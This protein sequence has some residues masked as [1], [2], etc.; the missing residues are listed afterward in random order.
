M[1]YSL[2]VEL[3][4][5]QVVEPPRNWDLLLLTCLIYINISEDSSFSFFFYIFL[6]HICFG[7]NETK[8]TKGKLYGELRPV[9]KWNF[10]ERDWIFRLRRQIWPC[11]ICRLKF[12]TYCVILTMTKTSYNIRNNKS[13]LRLRNFREVYFGKKQLSDNNNN[14]IVEFFNKTDAFSERLQ[15]ILINKRFVYIIYNNK[16]ALFKDLSDC[17]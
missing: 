12:S 10:K 1:S 11:E 16:C 2:S 6:I 8:L 9:V 5:L 13:D 15:Q 17:F 14:N 7:F 3:R 4:W